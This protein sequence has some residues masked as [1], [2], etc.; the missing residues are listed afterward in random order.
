MS[1]ETHDIEHHR[2]HSDWVWYVGVAAGGIAWFLPYQRLIPFSEWATAQFPVA[3]DSH[4]GEVI[5]FF[6]YDV[7]KV[8]LLLT[9]MS[10]LRAWYEAGSARKNAGPSVWQA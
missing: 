10:S 6:L 2:E 7:P 3:R 8:L 9:L 4:T 5:A 1:T